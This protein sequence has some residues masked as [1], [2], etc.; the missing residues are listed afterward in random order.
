MVCDEWDKAIEQILPASQNQVDASDNKYSENSSN[1][2]EYFWFQIHLEVMI[3]SLSH[4]T[5]KYAF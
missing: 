2:N 1:E 5:E 4:V 3:L